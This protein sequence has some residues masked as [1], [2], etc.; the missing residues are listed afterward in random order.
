MP[1]DPNIILDV[2]QNPG[3][4][5]G[6]LMSM[7]E[8]AQQMQQYK[9]EN[10]SQNALRA[11]F[12]NPASIDPKTN[13]LTPNALRT[14]YAADPEMGVKLQQE[15]LDAQVKNLQIQHYQT[16]QGKVK[17]DFASSVAGAGYDAYQDAIDSGQSEKDAI[18][19]GQAARNAAAKNGGGV[20]GDDVVD[21]IT[22][23]PFV[24]S[25]ARALASTNKEWLADQTERTRSKQAD[26]ALRR[27]D[28]AADRA[29]KALTERETHDE[30]LEAAAAARE[31]D[32]DTRAQAAEKRSEGS[33]WQV[34]TDPKTNEQ[35][36]YNPETAQATTL[37]G[38]PY[39]PG[40][41][42]KIA[43]G[44]AGSGFSPEMGSLM[45]AL[46]ERGISLPTGMRSKEQQ[47]ELYKGLLDR[48]KGKTPDEIADMIKTGQIEFGAQKKETVTAAGIAGKVEVAANEIEQ[49]IPLVED[50]SSKVSRG[51]FMPINKLLQ[52]GEAQ[53]SDPNLRALKIRINSLLNA[54]DM[55][56]SRGGIDK[57]K[58]EEVRNLLMSA[59]SPEVLKAGLQSFKLES[60][61]AHKAAVAATKVPELANQ[62]ANQA[63]APKRF[64]YDAQG[65]LVPQ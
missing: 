22:G 6:Q 34:L 16:D 26:A 47:V 24:P 64:K 60:D 32:A 56:A 15:G 53:L 61:A 39:T 46:A 19:A 27:Q 33:K 36:R 11:V 30:A 62:P 17:F 37:D 1:T 63:G 3:P 9:R 23:T 10:D 21:G 42:Q 8:F 5:P 12:S 29:D 65:N 59:D 58:R 20:V 25:N 50:A 41:A 13:F 43:G 4:Q 14:V 55:L 57:D 49:F 52:T 51:N 54:Y 48:N 28:A 31:K 35:Y 18:S 40:G 45:G 38:K 44:G 2:N 7:L